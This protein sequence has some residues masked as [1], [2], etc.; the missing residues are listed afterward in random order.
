MKDNDHVL[1]VDGA[2][3]V[4]QGFEEVVSKN[5]NVAISSVEGRIETDRRETMQF[6]SL[7][8]FALLLG[9]FLFIKIVRFTRSRL[10]LAK[11]KAQQL[12]GLAAEQVNRVQAAHQ[13]RK[14]RSVMM[15]ETI[16]EMTR[17]AVG[18][19]DT[20]SKEILIAELR[21]AIENGNHELASALESALK[22][23]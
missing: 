14:V 17:T 22:K 23:A 3:Y 11:E 4:L 2:A 9:I 8:V 7:I 15:D 21:K 12:R 18:A 19:S 16:R 13:R 6:V 20:K 10:S 5:I 1:M